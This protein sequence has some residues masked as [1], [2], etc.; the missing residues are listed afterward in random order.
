MALNLTRIQAR[1]LAQHLIV[2][3]RREL[4]ARPETPARSK[5]HEIAHVRLVEGCTTASYA[6]DL[7]P[8]AVEDDVESACAEAGTNW[9]GRLGA[10]INS[11][12]LDHAI[13]SLVAGWDGP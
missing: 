13:D 8:F 3:N 9:R 6:L 2:L 4:A 5:K 1:R 12:W 7:T 10:E 11:D